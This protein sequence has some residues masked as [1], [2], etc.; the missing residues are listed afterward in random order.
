M[1]KWETSAATTLWAMPDRGGLYRFWGKARLIDMTSRLRVAALLGVMLL[2]MVG[3]TYLMVQSFWLRNYTDLEMQTARQD[4][5]RMLDAI[6]NELDQLKAATVDYAVWN[7][8]YRYT[9][10]HNPEFITANFNAP[11]LVNLRVGLIVIRDAAGRVLYSATVA[12]NGTDLVAVPASLLEQLTPRSTQ[13]EQLST[14]VL[15]EGVL[16]V[17]MQ[18]I[19]DGQ[20]QGPA[21]GTLIFGRYFD[22]TEQARLE[23]LTHLTATWL[24]GDDTAVAR[25]LTRVPIAQMPTIEAVDDEHLVGRAWLPDVNGNPALMFEIEI[26]RPIFQQGQ[27]GL[28]YFIGLFALFGVI[29]SGV[30]YIFIMRWSALRQKQQAS[31]ARLQ[32]V[33]A[34]A[35]IFLFATDAAGVVTLLRGRGLDAMKPSEPSQ[36]IGRSVFDAHSPLPEP[37]REDIRRALTGETFTNTLETRGLAFEMWYSAHRDEHGRVTDVIG[38]GT[39][40]TERKALEMMWKRYAFIANTSKEFM[41]LI[42]QAR[43]YVAVNDAYCK[44]HDKARADIVGKTLA[45]VWGP[46]RYETHIQDNLEQCFAGHE[47]HYQAWFEFAA[48]GRRYLDVAYY[49]YF[50]REVVTHVVVVSHDDTE[51]RQATEALDRERRLLRTVIDNVPDQIFVRDRA[52]RFVLNNLSDARA[53]GVSDPDMLIGKSDA[54]FYPPDLA[55][56]YQADNRQ[57][58]ETG[59]PLINREEPSATQAGDS[60]RW[61]L[62]TKVP[63]RDG[64]GQVIGVVGIARDISER[65]QAE[66]L[67][68]QQSEQLRLLY[69]ASQRLNRTLDLTEIYQAICDFISMIAPNDNLVVST[70]DPETQLITCRAFWMENNWLDVSAFPPIPL[71]AEGKGTQSLVI[72]TGQAMLISDYQARQRTARSVYYVNDQTNELLTEV[73]PDEEVARSALIVP[74]KIGDKVSG[75]IQVISYR[76]NAYTENQLK[77]LEALALHIASAEKNALLYARV[78]TE[79]SERKLAE[80]ALRESEQR[81]RTLVETSPDA[82]TLTD[83]HARLVM[84]N[85]RAAELHRFMSVDDM[86]GTDALE[87]I[88]PEDRSRAHAAILRPQAPGQGRDAKLTMLRKDGSHF[89]AELSTSTVADAQG[90][91]Q[92]IMIIVRDITERKALEDALQASEEQHRMLVENMGEGVGV[93]DL[94]ERF[95]FVNPAAE[96]IFGVPPGQLTGRMLREFVSPEEFVR[97]QEETAKRRTRQQS[98]YETLIAC[99]GGEKRHLLVTATPKFNDDGQLASTFGVFRDITG[100]KQAEEALQTAHAQNQQL[101]T[102]ISSILIGIGPDDRITH[103]NAPAEAAFGLEAVHVIDRPFAECDIPWDS[104]E[105]NRCVATVRDENHPLHLSKIRYTRRDSKEGFLN[106]TVSPFVGN[107]SGR[108]GCLLLA[109]DITEYK[110]MEMQLAQ[111]QKLEA[112]GQLAAGIAHEI[113]TPIQYVGDNTRFLQESF[114]EIVALLDKYHGLVQSARAGALG[115]EQLAGVEAVEAKTDLDYLTQEIPKAIYE[116]LGGLA[117]VA[118]I[119]RAM[120]E[121]SHPDIGEKVATNL[122]KAIANTIT[123]A[124]NEWKYVAEMQTELAADLPLVPCLPGEF[125]QVILNLLVNAAQSIAD[126][127]G[128]GSHGKGTITVATRHVGNWAEI[129]VRDTGTGIPEAARGKIFD[130]FFTTK[131]VG[132]GTGQGL[133]ISYNAIVEKHGGTITFETELGRGTTFIIRLPIA[134]DSNEHARDSAQIEAIYAA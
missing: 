54:D 99:P 71:E 39:N 107:Q 103:W 35:P 42:D 67:L 40:I 132:K 36:F 78:Q 105:V 97:L 27:T 53:M 124:R 87:L 13:S 21:H 70:F 60:Q 6:G 79:L 74:L 91:P 89:P 109:E 85:R 16:F 111:A 48:L 52:G 104:A 101:L 31:E 32:T 72:H 114:F 108:S 65:K 129:T 110:I 130:P 3:G 119:V 1:L 73:P 66:E 38:V 8:A 46:A 125:N 62:T 82:V 64:Q 19:L 83:L 113:N 92:A 45:E 2:T 84:V 50:D 126:V 49:P 120:R 86:I 100:R 57:V 56:R 116:S 122:N 63:L 58:M 131:E 17:A 94:D 25:V 30:L 80:E 117:R 69:E 37:I 112:I 121:F 76:L 115:Q 98:T 26:S 20:G 41:T 95:V 12:P 68:R 128:D 10:D 96:S 18:P 34:A 77:L 15:P 59:R 102:S 123:V 51:H 75:V 127:V 43:T 11:V 44:A 47:M 29:S 93:V 61:A 90:R 106:I 23:R 4:V 14:V 55:A 133:A 28:T 5:V 22:A 134:G 24:R 7:D 81:Y 88:A 118:E 33:V 9:E